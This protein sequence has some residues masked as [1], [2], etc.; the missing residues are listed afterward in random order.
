MLQFDGGDGSVLW[1][2]PEC[3][4]DGE[5][6]Y[7]RVVGMDGNQDEFFHWILTTVMV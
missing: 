5:K 6:V 3:A 4:Y 2:S 7:R 1:A